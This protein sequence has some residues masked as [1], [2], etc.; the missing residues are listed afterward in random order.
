VSIASQGVFSSVAD[1]CLT[2]NSEND[3]LYGASIATGYHLSGFQV[4]GWVDIVMDGRTDRE[5]GRYPTDV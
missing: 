5:A 2:R 1:V 4:D 3:G